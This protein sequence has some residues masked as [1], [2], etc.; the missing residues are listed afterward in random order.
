MGTAVEPQSIADLIK[1]LGG[2]SP[3]R[4]RLKPYPG[5]AT[6]R[7]LIRLNGR[8]DRIYELVD[9]TLVEKV[10]GYGEGIIAAEIIFLMLAFVKP[11]RLGFVGGPDATMRIM[12]RIARAP[13][14]SFVSRRKFPNGKVT[15]SPVPDLVPDLAVEVISKGDRP[16]EIKRK[17]K[18]YFRSGVRA[19]WVIDPPTESARVYSRPTEF[20]LI[21]KG[22]TIDGGDVLPGF[23][24][25]LADLFADLDDHTE[26]AR[27][28]KKK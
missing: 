24:L 19:V 22:G 5:T 17:L 11:R 18:E 3:R 1:E 28:G 13:D 23:K 6:V 26:P 27:N 9:G 12:P 16:G 14:V 20:T 7:D 15:R 2:V 4:I 10:M 8:Q 25:H 21:P